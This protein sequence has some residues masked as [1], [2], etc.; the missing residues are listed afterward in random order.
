[1]C[2][3]SIIVPIYNAEKYLNQC[4]DSILRQTYTDFEL[5]LID[6]GSQDNSKIICKN[7]LLKDS[8]VVYKYKTNG[9]ASSARNLGISLAMGKYIVFIDSDDFIECDYLETVY[10]AADGDNDILVIEAPNRFIN[11]RL[12]KEVLEEI[13]YVGFEAHKRFIIS[14][15]LKYSEPHSKLFSAKIIKE[16]NIFFPEGVIIGEDGIFIAQYLTHVSRI[17]SIS[18]SG[19]NYRLNMGS[20][21]SKLY[22]FDLEYK[23]YL[24]WKE[25]LKNYISRYAVDKSSYKYMWYLLSSLFRRCLIS[26]SKDD[27]LSYYQ[28]VKKIMTLNKEDFE[29]YGTCRVY[30]I[31]GTLSKIIIK[32]RLYFIIPII[33][34]K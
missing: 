32:N 17:K 29:N 23:G 8:R 1:M 31:K 21:Q 20:V 22:S 12:C 5:L 2:K 14:G 27:N 24:I 30:G 25:M 10:K 15:S 9:G 26:I 19:Y 13:N 6:D 28:K 16:N 4:I 7:Y 34:N 18:A 3:I 33:F 11:D